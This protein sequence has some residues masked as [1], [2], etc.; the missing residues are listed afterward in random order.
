MRSAALQTSPSSISV[1]QRSLLAREILTRLE[2][3]NETPE[4]A[5]FFTTPAWQNFAVELRQWVA[6]PIDYEELLDEIELLEETGAECAATEVAE[7]YQ[8]MRWSASP[9]VVQL[10]EQLN[11]YY[12]NANVR[13]AISADLINR[14]AAT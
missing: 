8:V 6:E 5:Q 12:R 3:A 1:E 14:S 10:A 13:V 7:Y 9:P 4:Q 2:R 11:T